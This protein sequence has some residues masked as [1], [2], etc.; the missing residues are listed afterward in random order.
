MKHV[1]FERRFA[2]P[3]EERLRDP[4]Y[5]S[6]WGSYEQGSLRWSDLYS[7]RCVVVLGEGKCGKTHE[8][9][10]QRNKIQSQGQ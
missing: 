10:Q 8:F 5:L 2:P 7:N 3:S 4:D 9:K 6:N 1:Q